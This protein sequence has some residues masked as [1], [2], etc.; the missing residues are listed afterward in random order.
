[1]FF[2]TGRYKIGFFYHVKSKEGRVT[3]I[4]ALRNAAF[5]FIFYT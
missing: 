3:E 2:N 5:V 1:M 4:R